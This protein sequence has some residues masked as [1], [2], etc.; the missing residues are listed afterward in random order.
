LK[1]RKII[2]VIY[3]EACSLTR[4]AVEE[5]NDAIVKANI[6]HMTEAPRIVRPGNKGSEGN[7]V[8]RTLFRQAMAAFAGSLF[9]TQTPSYPFA[10]HHQLYHATPTSSR[11]GRPPATC[12][13]TRE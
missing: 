1:V 5:T 10:P 13:P 9:T 7:K 6:K 4:L 12:G 3:T 8:V 11:P 2:E